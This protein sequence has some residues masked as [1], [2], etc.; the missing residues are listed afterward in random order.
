MFSQCLGN[1]IWLFFIFSRTYADNNEV[2][3]FPSRSKIVLRGFFSLVF[4]FFC[5][6]FFVVP[7]ILMCNAF[8]RAFSSS[9]KMRAS[10]FRILFKVCYDRMISWRRLYNYNYEQWIIWYINLSFVT[11]NYAH[12]SSQVFFSLK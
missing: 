8:L 2:F 11:H 4:L 7:Y 1:M 3:R 9:L 6:F 5:Y 12:T 10:Y